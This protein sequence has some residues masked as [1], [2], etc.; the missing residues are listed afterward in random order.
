MLICAKN[1]PYV[2]GTSSDV[3]MPIAPP[4][5]LST[6]THTHLLLKGALLGAL[7]KKN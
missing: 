6:H 5:A 4:D 7:A 1:V 2:H 3:N